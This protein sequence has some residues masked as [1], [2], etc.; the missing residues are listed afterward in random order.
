[1][2]AMEEKILRDGEVRSSGI[3]KVDSFLNHQL[4]IAFLEEIGQEFYELFKGQ[5][6]SKIL[7]I[8]TSGIAI[9]VMTARYFRVPVVFAKKSESL[10][11][12]GSCYESRV[13]SYTKQRE[14][15]IRVSKKYLSA[16]DRVLI[17]DDFLAKGKAIQGLLDVIRQSGAAVGGIGIA[18]EKGFQGGGDLIRSEGYQVESL[19]ILDEMTEDSIRFRR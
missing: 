8:E 9:A 10:N 19:A 17:I 11:L 1:M 6:I 14:Y 12:D 13:Y 4:D 16:E 5:D 3:L 15:Q 7:T 2:Q 18:I